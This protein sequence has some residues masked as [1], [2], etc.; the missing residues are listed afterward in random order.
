LVS[1]NGHQVVRAR[2]ASPGDLLAA[3][4]AGGADVALVGLRPPGVWLEAIRAISRGDS[5]LPIVVIGSTGSNEEIRSAMLAGGHAFLSMPVSFD[6]LRGAIKAVVAR[7]PRAGDDA[8]PAA[9]AAGWLVAVVGA[10]GGTGRSTIALNAAVAAGRAGVDT[11]LVDAGGGFGDIATLACLVRLDHTLL[12]AAEDPSRVDAFLAPGPLGIG[13]LAAPARP[14]DA[15]GI[16]ADALRAALQQLRGS[17]DLV[18][19]DAPAIVGE[20]HATI[21]ELADELV[22]AVVGDMAAVKNTGA[23]LGLLEALGLSRDS[24]IVLNRTGEP[25]ALDVREVRHALGRIDH[26]VPFDALRAARAG[27]TGVPVVVSDP[28]SGLARSLAEIAAAIT[29]TP[30]PVGP[31]VASRR[32]PRFGLRHGTWLSRLRSP[33]TPVAAASCP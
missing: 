26:V 31:A 13:I 23:Y 14:V 6:E 25:G 9:R 19:V 28:Q 7:H 32:L 24:R 29:G 2:C 1:H 18:I 27:N 16:S 20:A 33:G 12:D 30:A 5:A 8:V 4:R 17:H 3:V 21:V 10:R 11:V 15:E 22:V